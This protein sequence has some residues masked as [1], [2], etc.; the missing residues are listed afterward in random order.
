MQKQQKS[1]PHG[2]KT[3]PT[4]QRMCRK[5]EINFYPTPT[6]GQNKDNSGQN[7]SSSYPNCSSSSSSNATNCSRLNGQQYANVN[8]QN[9]NPQ[10][11]CFFSSNRKKLIKL[12]GVFIYF[13]VVQL[14]HSYHRHSVSNLSTMTPMVKT[15]VT[16][17]PA[18]PIPQHQKA[19]TNNCVGLHLSPQLNSHLSG[20]NSS[21]TPSITSTI[22][23]S[24]DYCKYRVFC[25][26]VSFRL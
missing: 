5:S 22:I 11:R 19:T 9:A 25:L 6:S 8:S 2:P 4:Q 26:L 23:P 18:A 3:K 17:T 16:I 1:Q 10:V 7:K 15:T 12:I 21:I 14:H 24:G 13:V 20:S